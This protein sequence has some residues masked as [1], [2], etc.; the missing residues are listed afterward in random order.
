[1]AVNSVTTVVFHVV[2]E[3]TLE[4]LWHSTS[5]V[6]SLVAVQAVRRNSCYLYGTR[7]NTRNITEQHMNYLYSQTV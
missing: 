4:T 1:M 5:A 6:Y 3:K 2:L 7:E